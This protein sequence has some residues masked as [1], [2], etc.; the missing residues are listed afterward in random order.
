M[1]SAVNAG[2]GKFFPRPQSMA[3]PATTHAGRSSGIP[4]PPPLS[5]SKKG[6]YHEAPPMNSR[7]T[8]VGG[9]QSISSGVRAG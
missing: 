6:A 4:Q 3:C 2:N 7:M 8:E 5:Q 9:M 1:T